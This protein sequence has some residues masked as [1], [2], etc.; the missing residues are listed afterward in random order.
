MAFWATT[1]VY[2]L[3]GVSMC[4]C[5]VLGVCVCFLG[6]LGAMV[7]MLQGKKLT[8]WVGDSRSI[9]GYYKYM[10]VFL[11]GCVYVFGRV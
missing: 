3:L 11:W 8:T 5:F 1:S 10:F 9:L 6:V 4:L 2:F 7:G